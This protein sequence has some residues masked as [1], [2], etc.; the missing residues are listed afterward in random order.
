MTRREDVIAVARHFQIY[1]D[2]FDATPYGSGH[3]ND[4]YAVRY[5]Q[6]GTIVRYVFQRVNTAIFEDTVALMDNVARVTRHVRKKLEAA[7]ASEISR[8]V[9]TLVP[10]R[11]GQLYYQNG[12]G[13]CWRVYLMI[14]NSEAHDVLATPQQAEAVARAFGRFQEMMVDL[15]G[16]RLAEVLPGFHDARKRFD[17]LVRA[18][19]ADACNRA[20]DV[21]QEI[22]FVMDREDI[23]DVLAVL[24]ARD[25]IPERITHNDA[26]LNNLL[27]DAQTGEALCVI[28]LDTVMPG[29]ALYDFGDM[30]RTA[31][32]TAS[33]DTPDLSSVA[34]SRS[35]FEALA[36]GYWSV[37]QAFLTPQEKAHLVF[38][39][40]W[41]TL[42]MGMRFLTDYLAGDTYY[43]IHWST[44]NLDRCRTQFKLIESIEA[45]EEDLNRFVEQL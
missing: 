42:V 5:D 35:Y 10:S 29:L 15:P 16:P 33:E 24:Y 34:L 25:E 30:V 13:A 12:A 11:D 45:Q 3:I 17:A 22:G 14:E 20:A 37:A 1:G 40:K 28:D 27:F 26:K 43:K 9:L 41:M 39:G 21:K 18:A 2:P 7:G 44:H 8:R 32:C 36:R 4:T 6:A 23:V 19:E 31:A 38:S